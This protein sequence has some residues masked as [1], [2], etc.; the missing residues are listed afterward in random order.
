MSFASDRA[1][2]K[3]A[4][5]MAFSMAQEKEN[6]LAIVGY[7]IVEHYDRNGRL[8]SVQPF[9]NIIT[10]AGDQ[11]Y[12]QKG[13]VG[14]APAAAA[15]PTAAACMKLGTGVTAAS[16]SGAGAALG[17]T[18]IG[19]S[20]KA[21]DATFPQAAAVGGDGGWNA[22]YKTTWNAGEATNAAITEVVIA[23]D[24]AN[25]TSTAANSYSRTV[26]SSVNKAAGDTLAVT[27]NHKF[28]GA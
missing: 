2:V 18:F 14:I 12:A 21:F 9:A 11:Y 8:K 3:D 25:A 10:T 15:A 20:N 1:L 13:I 24:N 26:I 16:K 23:N 22:I 19:A 28:L 4:A 17:A 6:K 27:W 5:R 7:G